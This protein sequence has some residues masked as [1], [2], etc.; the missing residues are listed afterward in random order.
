[1][2]N[3]FSIQC[4]E[5]SKCF[6]I[7]ENPKARLKQAIWRNKKR[8][9]QEF[10]ANRNIT[11]NINQ[12]ET[13]GIV[14]SNGSG[15]S[16]L[17]QM[18]CGTL[19]PTSGTV[20]THGRISALLELGSGFNPEFSGLENIYLNGSILGLSTE[21]IKES[22]DK[23]LNFAD[24]GNFISQPVKS[25]SSG[26]QLRLAFAIAINVEPEIL[27][28]DEAL[29]VGDERF[30][31]KC[32]SKIKSLRENG[33]TILFVSHSA[34]SIVDLCDRAILMSSGKV[35][36]DGKPKK[37]IGSYQKLL[38][39]PDERKDAVLNEIAESFKNISS[40]QKRES[41]ESMADSFNQKLQK[42]K[43]YD[44]FDPNMKPSSTV[45]YEEVGA[46][47]CEACIR[48]LTGKKVNKIT[49][50]EKYIYE[51]RAKFTI[52]SRKIAFGML[53]KTINGTELG[54]ATT[55]PPQSN[56]NLEV[57]KGDEYLVRFEFH[58]TLNPGIYFMNAGILGVF[59]DE[60]TYLHR[61]SDSV[62]FHVLPVEANKSTALVDFDITFE[63]KNQSS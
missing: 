16:T 32:F 15:K 4:K 34:S 31:R 55:C 35:I 5:L 50:G 47:I 54:G 45:Y 53:I 20:S 17:L 36:A 57:S 56:S 38:Y 59:E 12:G 10:W 44:S 28:V 58:C 37:I 60:Q 6:R 19:T 41:E 1:M 9:Y 52:D 7:Y 11:L 61:I 49:K 43:I 3:K 63:I 18:I 48:D 27:I 46:K 24:I 26:M 2:Q 8:Y 30:Q 33:S 13:I 25:Y 42:E 22:L 62:L 39:A 21:E 14:G 29:A 40:I 51:Y 23:I